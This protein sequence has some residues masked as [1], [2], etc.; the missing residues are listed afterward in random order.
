MAIDHSLPRRH[1][2]EEMIVITGATGVA[3][4]EVVQA[5]LQRQ[6]RVRV[7]VR[8]PA[9]ARRLF[10]D[11]VEVVAGDYADL[12][13]LRGALQGASALFLSGG[14]DHRRVAFECA[15]IDAAAAAGVRRIVKLSSIV[16]EQ[17]APVLYWGWHG[18]IEAHLRRSGVPAVVLR[19]SFFM[20][21]LLAVAGQV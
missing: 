11:A 14:D 3:G 10:G 1:G 7:V 12:D 21:N 17:G 5:L 15:A 20:S 19:A 8:D 9:K 6:E 4:S 18:R 2:D 13:G 16:A